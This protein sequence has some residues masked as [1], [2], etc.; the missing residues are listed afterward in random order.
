MLVLSSVASLELLWNS[1]VVL[2]E[3]LRFLE[4]FRGRWTRDIAAFFEFPYELQSIFLSSSYGYLS[5]TMRQVTEFYRLSLDLFSL[6]WMTEF[7]SW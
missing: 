2:E 3:P 7:A 4:L 1:F 6:P 5:V